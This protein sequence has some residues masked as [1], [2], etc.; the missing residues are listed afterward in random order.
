M[1]DI[2]IIKT[3]AEEGFV[4]AGIHSGQVACF[5]KV[6]LKF[7][8]ASNL[9]EVR[10]VKEPHTHYLWDSRLVLDAEPAK[11]TVLSQMDA[12]MKKLEEELNALRAE[13]ESISTQ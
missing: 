9:I 7:D 4:V 13:R 11:E 1:R 8:W 6:K 10:K 12:H 2:E 3:G 5:Q